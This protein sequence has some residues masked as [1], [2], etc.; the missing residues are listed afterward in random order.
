MCVRTY[1]YIDGKTH[2]KY[3]YIY[4][5][6][7]IYTHIYIYLFYVYAYMYV[8]VCAYVYTYIY[9][10]TYTYIN[11][12]EGSYGSMVYQKRTIQTHRKIHT[13]IHSW[14]LR[15][16][17]STVTPWAMASHISMHTHTYQCKQTP[18]HT[19]SWRLR[20]LTSTVTPWV[21]A[22]HRATY[23]HE[24]I[25]THKHTYPHAYVHSWRLR[26]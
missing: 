25:Q 26:E 11:V 4:I 5:C 13:C 17:I 14:C 21:M 8:Y 1:V 2:K 16:L 7:Y 12:C 24:Y 18:M 6:I 19:H 22:S 15:E 23:T 20:E 3:I 10:H 9:I